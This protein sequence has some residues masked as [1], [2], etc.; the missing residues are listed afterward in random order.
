MDSTASKLLPELDSTSLCDVSTSTESQQSIVTDVEPDSG[1]FLNSASPVTLE[2]C[3]IAPS[4]LQSQFTENCDEEI[5]SS[6][7]DVN[8]DGGTMTSHD[9]FRMRDVSATRSDVSSGGSYFSCRSCWSDRSTPASLDAEPEVDEEL[10]RHNERDDGE[11]EVL[12]AAK[13]ER[14]PQ[15]DDVTVPSRE[16]F[17]GDEVVPVPEVSSHEQDVCETTAVVA[18]ERSAKSGGELCAQVESDRVDEN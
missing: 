10:Q 14:T 6:G 3:S 13:E 2:T 4:V 9:G 18:T 8:V 11:E 12:Q 1:S 7:F 15:A 5:T 16:E 17:V